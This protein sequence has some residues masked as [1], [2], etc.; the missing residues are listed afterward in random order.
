LLVVDATFI[1][2]AAGDAMQ[3]AGTVDGNALLVDPSLMAAD[4]SVVIS[5][6]QQQMIADH[7][8]SELPPTP[9]ASR[10]RPV[11]FTPE[12]VVRP[13]LAAGATGHK[14]ALGSS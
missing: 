11:S 7:A 14:P 3:G 6:W 5:R 4:G 10:C 2:R 12:A 9:T 8:L 13:I 1:V